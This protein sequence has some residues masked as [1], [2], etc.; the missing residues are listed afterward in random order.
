MLPWVLLGLRS[1]A[2]EDLHTSAVELVYGQTLREPGEFLPTAKQAW[3]TARFLK[4]F[5]HPAQNFAPVPITRHGG[6]VTH[7]PPSLKEAT[8]VYIRHGALGTPLQPL[9]DGP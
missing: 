7:I 3:D 6:Q 5:A 4:D 2:K 9:Y 1:A 8:H